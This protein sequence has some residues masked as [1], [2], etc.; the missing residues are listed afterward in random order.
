M[1]FVQN[2]ALPLVVLVSNFVDDFMNSVPSCLDEYYANVV[3]TYLKHDDMISEG[4][5]EN[6]AHGSRS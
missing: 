4:A 1:L 5:A 6:G 2:M 3:L